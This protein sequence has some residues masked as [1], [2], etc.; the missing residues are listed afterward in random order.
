LRQAIERLDGL[1]AGVLERAKSDAA[2]IGAA[3]VEYLHAFG[4]VAYAY[5]W[6]RMAAA[7]GD[8]DFGRGKQATARF[9]FARLLPRMESLCLAVEAGAESLYAL[10]EAQF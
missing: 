6:A 10:D 7:A 4:Y 5:L 9:Y 1:T 3:S 2:E 8:D